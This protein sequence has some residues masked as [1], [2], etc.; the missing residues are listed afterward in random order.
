M[1]WGFTCMVQWL[2][3]SCSICYKR[4]AWFKDH[5][6]LIKVQF[7]AW[8]SDR[9]GISNVQS[10]TEGLHGCMRK[11]SLCFGV[12]TAVH[13]HGNVKEKNRKIPV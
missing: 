9:V 6:V 4:S 13:V 1:L 3:G 2:S 8:C 10:A 5:C 11:G 7:T 12:Q